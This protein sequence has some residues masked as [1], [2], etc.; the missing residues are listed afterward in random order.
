LAQLVGGDAEQPPARA[1]ALG[2]KPAQPLDGG[3]E[4]LGGEVERELGRGDAPAQVRGD[5]GDVAAVEHRERLVV[6]VARGHQQVLV[7]RHPS[8]TTRGGRRV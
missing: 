3:R 4:R 6:A 5:V 8:S 1:A 7:R 2:P